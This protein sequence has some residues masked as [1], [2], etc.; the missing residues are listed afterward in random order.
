METKQVNKHRTI[1]LTNRPPVRIDDE[2]WPIIAESKWYEGQYEFQANRSGWL[3]VRQHADG[4][5]LVYGGFDSNWPNERSRRGGE[6]LIPP[7]DGPLT[8]DDGRTID[9]VALVQAIRRVAETVG[10]EECAANCIA[11]LPADEI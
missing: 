8:P 3:K 4:R 10:A 2:A 5:T 7:G 6:L 11:D 1:T 9:G